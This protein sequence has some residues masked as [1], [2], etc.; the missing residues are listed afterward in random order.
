LVQLYKQRY[1]GNRSAGGGVWHHETTVTAGALDPAGPD[2][3]NCLQVR[4]MLVSYVSIEDEQASSICTELNRT[5]LRGLS[6]RL[7]C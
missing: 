5:E 1:I 7:G 4:S 6:G 2:L 3:V